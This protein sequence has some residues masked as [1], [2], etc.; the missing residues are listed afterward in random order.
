[1][2]DYFKG[3]CNTFKIFVVK[4]LYAIKGLKSIFKLPGAMNLVFKGDFNFKRSL[5]PNTDVSLS[6][7]V[8]R[9]NERS[10]V[11]K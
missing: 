4:L 3:H 9:L 11:L 5:I 7:F 1:M 8:K 6:G 10:F 2:V